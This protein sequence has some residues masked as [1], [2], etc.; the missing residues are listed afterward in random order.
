MI[1]R[2]YLIFCLF[3]FFL[4]SLTFGEDS[5]EEASFD[6]GD[7]VGHYVGSNDDLTVSIELSPYIFKHFNFTDFVTVETFDEGDMGY[8]EIDGSLIELVYAHPD[9]PSKQLK[10]QEDGTL[11]YGPRELILKP[12]GPNFLGIL[13][14]FNRTLKDSSKAAHYRSDGVIPIQ[15]DFTGGTEPECSDDALH[16]HNLAFMYESGTQYM[17]G[18]DSGMLGMTDKIPD[19][20]KREGLID[21]EKAYEYYL[22]ASEKGYVQSMYNLAVYH[23]K[24]W[25][26]EKDLSKA[27]AWFR[28]AADMGHTYSEQAL[29]KYLYTGAEGVPANE[30]EALKYWRSAASKGNATAQYK[31]GRLLSSDPDSTEKQKKSGEEFIWISALRDYPS[32]YFSLFNIFHDKGN[33]SDEPDHDYEAFAI[34]FL[35]QA[36][37]LGD[38][39]AHE[40]VEAL[41]A[42][43]DGSEDKE[44]AATPD[45]NNEDPVDSAPASMDSESITLLANGRSVYVVV[46]QKN[47]GKLIYKGAIEVDNPLT[48][49]KCGPVGIMF[50]RGE[51]LVIE[52]GD[53]R[54][55]P[56][57]S[58]AAKITIE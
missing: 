6:R 42:L 10:I 1:T 34:R 18:Q 47:D 57:A 16:L 50:T 56:S 4:L 28:K 31:L 21:Y 44:D 37:Y 17:G 46:T 35:M 5:K 20:E 19:Y 7:L 55:R 32:A 45:F 40:Y 29:A 39:D 36:C 3:S 27:V 23:E 53:E 26:V 25:H 2:D 54:F 41:R 14:Q 22:K 30:E 33:D 15:E 49:D 58:G 48:L 13:F 12:V 51:C 52:I 11:L 9:T 24:G 43:K 8:W 38:S